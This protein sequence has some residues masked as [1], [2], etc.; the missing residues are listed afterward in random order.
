MGCQKRDVICNF[1]LEP[2]GHRGILTSVRGGRLS[3]AV[4]A[5]FI[6]EALSRQ[7]EWRI[8][9]LTTPRVSHVGPDNF[10]V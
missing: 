6:L 4:M 8:M 5:V 3:L 10:T 2:N 1:A 7:F 9:R